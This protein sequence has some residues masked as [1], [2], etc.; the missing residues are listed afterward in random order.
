MEFFL[1]IIFTWMEERNI[2][3]GIFDASGE[4]VIGYTKELPDKFIPEIQSKMSRLDDWMI[5]P[6]NVNGEYCGC[7]CYNLEE[8]EY[9]DP[10][11]VLTVCHLLDIACSRL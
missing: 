2:P 3:F 8:S 11:D 7:I 6:I 5:Y 4:F 9:E 1:N 10:W